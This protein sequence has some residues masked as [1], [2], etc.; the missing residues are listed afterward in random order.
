MTHIPKSLLIS[1]LAVC[2]LVPGVVEAHHANP[3]VAGLIKP[4]WYGMCYFVWSIRDA[5]Y[6]D[7]LFDAMLTTVPGLGHLYAGSIGALIAVFIWSIGLGGY[8]LYL[9]SLSGPYDEAW[10]FAYFG[11]LFMVAAHL[12]DTIFAPFAAAR[13]N[14]K[15][16]REK[17]ESSRITVFP[18]LALSPRGDG[19][20]AGVMLWF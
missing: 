2:L 6:E 5:A 3:W 12:F 20:R 15:H 10:P 18:V 11:M 16:A 4:V 9:N 8:W 14:R 13:H 7:P 17:A 1:L 19:M